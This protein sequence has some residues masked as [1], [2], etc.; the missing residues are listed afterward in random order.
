MA[1]DIIYSATSFDQKS[2]VKVGIQGR[3][4]HQLLDFKYSFVT[5]PSQKDTEKYNSHSVAV[6]RVNTLS[7]H[8]F[9]CKETTIDE[10]TKKVIAYSISE[11]FEL[12][13]KG[14]FEKEFFEER[15]KN[16]SGIENFINDFK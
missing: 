4:I 3:N 14:S 6:Q 15:I 10:K 9:W 7:G 11:I 1:W 5:V 2:K 16:C 13:F 8:N 12:N